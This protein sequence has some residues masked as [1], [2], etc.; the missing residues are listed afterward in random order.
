MESP[1]ERNWHTAPYDG[2]TGDGWV[3]TG[4]RSALEGTLG[5][6]LHLVRSNSGGTTVAIDLPVDA[7]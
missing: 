5:G 2:Y 1:V 3:R 6:D 4:D 7:E